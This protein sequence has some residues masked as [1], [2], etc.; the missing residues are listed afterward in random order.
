MTRWLRHLANEFQRI[1][2]LKRRYAFDTLLALGFLL[3][4]FSGL[5]LAVL[6]VSG[7]SLASGEADGLIVGFA[8][9]LFAASAASSACQDVQE[10][11]DQRTLEQLCIAPLPL[12]GLLAL[13]ALLGLAGALLTLLAALLCAHWATGGR[14][15]GD[16]AVVVAAC[17]LAA[18]ALVGLGYALAGV[19]LLAKRAELLLVLSFASVM[20]LVALPA[21][22]VNALALLPYSLGAAAA[23]AAAAGTTLPL[24]V[25]VFIAANALVWL[26]FGLVAYLWFERRARRLGVLGHF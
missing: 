13:R 24:S 12:W 7:K 20:A 8:V 14:L 4:L 11:T 3:F 22:P 6:S 1:V 17:L 2:A 9:W 23:R 26:V 19:M 15:Q 25:W 10:E 16:W 5:I 18:P 21:L